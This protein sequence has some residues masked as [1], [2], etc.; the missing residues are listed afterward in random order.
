MSKIVKAA[1]IAAATCFIVTAASAQQKGMSGMGGM[2]GMS[3]QK[4]V[5]KDAKGK[6]V[7]CPAAQK[8]MSGMGGM[9]GMSGQK[10]MG[11][12]GGMGG[13]SGQQGMGGM[14]G[15]SASR[16]WVEWAAG[17]HVRPA[18]YGWNGR[19]GRHVRPKEALIEPDRCFTNRGRPEQFGR[20]FFVR[21]CR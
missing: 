17:W 4:Q 1:A 11:G 8:G 18:G 13:M 16:V 14:G 20:P 21:T 3:G 9:G 15:M 7:A 19:H 10:G 12:M 2:S 6:E 5:C